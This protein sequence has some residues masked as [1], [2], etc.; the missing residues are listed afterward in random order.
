MVSLN[1]P[2]H[3]DNWKGWIGRYVGEDGS[4]VPPAGVPKWWTATGS[5]P[6]Q[7]LYNMDH[8]MEWPFLVVCEGPF[9]VMA[10]GSPYGPCLPGPGVAVIGKCMSPTQRELVMRHWGDKPVFVMFDGDARDDTYKACD[11]LEGKGHSCVMPVLLPDGKDPNDLPHG[12]VW[13]KVLSAAAM[14][15]VDLA[16]MKA[17]V[18]P[19]LGSSAA[20][21]SV[22]SHQ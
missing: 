7:T 22:D 2:D 19:V 16:K 11:R 14:R 3:I 21:H 10:L 15:G 18:P 6:S 8:A 1:Q 17:P 13:Q 12:A 4:G 20:Q 5:T 9:D